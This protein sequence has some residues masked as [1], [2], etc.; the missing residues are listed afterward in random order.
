MIASAALTG[1]RPFREE[2]AP[3]LV[4]E[5]GSNEVGGKRRRIS[6]TSSSTRYG[7]RRFGIGDEVR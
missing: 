2:A 7:S 3:A 6:P 5:G 1:T 4:D